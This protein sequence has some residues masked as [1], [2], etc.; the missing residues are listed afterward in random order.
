MQRCW[1][2]MILV[3]YMYKDVVPGREYLHDMVEFLDKVA[4]TVDTA[5]LTPEERNLLSIAYKNLIAGRRVFV[6]A[7]PLY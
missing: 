4:K 1:S 3:G 5:E 6:E 2:L 7:H